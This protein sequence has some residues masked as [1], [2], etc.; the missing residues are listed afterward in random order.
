MMVKYVNRLLA[1]YHLNSADDAKYNSLL[2]IE[3]HIQSGAAVAVAL[4]LAGGGGAALVAACS[5]R[6]PMGLVFDVGDAGGEGAG[7]LSY[8]SYS[9]ELYSYSPL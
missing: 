1:L 7:A 4:F 5:L 9:Y 3:E 2:L 6:R 8:T